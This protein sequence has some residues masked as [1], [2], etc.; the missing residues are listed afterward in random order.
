MSTELSI[1]D[2]YHKIPKY[3][4]DKILTEL[5]KPWLQQNGYREYL[6]ALPI[7]KEMS[8]GDNW[9]L[10]ALSR[11]L[12][13]LTL[14]DRPDGYTEAFDRD[15]PLLT[16]NEYIELVQ[17][18]GFEIDWP[19]H[20]D[21]FHC[22]I[23]TAVAGRANFEIVD[24]IHPAIK[25]KNLMIKRSPVTITLK[26][27]DYDLN[28][29]NNAMLY[30]TF[31]RSNRKTTDLSEGWGSNS[32]W[33]TEFRMDIETEQSYI[34]NLKNTL[35]LN[36]LNEETITELK[37]QNLTVAEAIELVVHRQF[38]ACTKE[39]K[40]LFPYEFKYEAPKYE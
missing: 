14:T 17:F 21:P 7:S 15:E 1:R 2:L 16:R 29:I 28:R 38:I 4:G 8:D 37:N 20:Y 10:Y 18:L 11:V 5:I 13:V 30:W 39:D 22:E 23:A 9:E 33:R 26:P 27:E 34:Y 3:K 40:D 12:D 32:Q 31:R 19:K 6:H 36:E 24:C 35:D 25:L